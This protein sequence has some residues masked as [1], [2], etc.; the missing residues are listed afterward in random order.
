LF[1]KYK[2][3]AAESRAVAKAGAR[4]RTATFVAPVYIQGKYI[5]VIFGSELNIW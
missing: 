5:N 4:V 3:H 1:I 2:L